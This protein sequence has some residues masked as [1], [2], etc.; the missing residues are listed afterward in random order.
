MSQGGVYLIIG[1]PGEGKS[2][3]TQRFIYGRNCFVF[4]VNNEY[5]DR[6]KY[7]G[8]TPIRLSSNNN[9]AR[10]RFISGDVDGFIK[11]CNTKRNT[12]CVFEEATAFFTGKTDK[13]MRRLLINR[14]NTGN[15]YLLLFHSI[16][17][18]PPVIIDLTS[19]IVL[20]KTNDE[21]ARVKAKFSRLL[22]YYENLS[23]Q[24]NGAKH[25]INFL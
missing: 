19:N 11:I 20:F 6:T 1:R 3:F 13:N 12:I 15:I 8:Q 2:P 9:D 24:P 4:D 10:S 14:Y 22:P 17:M 21:P 23:S 7:P 25:I 5:G 18:V 16:G